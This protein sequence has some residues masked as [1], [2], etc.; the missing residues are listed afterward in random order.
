MSRIGALLLIFTMMIFIGYGCEPEQL[1]Q[2]DQPGCGDNTDIQPGETDSPD[3]DCT[4]CEDDCGAC[5]TADGDVIY[6][7]DFEDDPLGTYTVANL[8]QD[9][10]H[11]LW[12]N[13][14]SEGNAEIVATEEGGKAFRFLYPEG[15]N[16]SVNWHLQL[17]R[18]Y[19]ELYY[20]Y[21]LRI[22]EEF[23]F[24]KGGKFGGFCGGTCTTGG[25]RADG[26]NGWSVRTTW[27]G[28]TVSR[29]P[30]EGLGSIVAYVYHADQPADNGQHYYWGSID[31]NWRYY[32]MGEW[33]WL[34]TRVKMNTPGQND[35]IVQ[36]WL[37]G[38]LVLDI[39]DFKFRDVDTFAIDTFTMMSMF[40]SVASVKDEYADIDEVII[41]TTPITHK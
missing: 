40:S 32:S 1:V 26:T 19:E 7:N 17:S 39:R 15:T 33:D 25:E 21:R 29:H 37:N 22:P 41:S 4:D 3:E 16:M 5:P 13:G 28:E 38:E 9:W 6:R 2:P 31:G 35:G 14:V 27:K 8:N 23:V 10:N 30:A 24:N 34:E 20:A 11:P 36:A 18:S 12:E